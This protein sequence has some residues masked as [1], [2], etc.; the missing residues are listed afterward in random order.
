MIENTEGILK[1]RGW[2]KDAVK[3]EAFFIPGKE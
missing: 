1:R 2:K 3:S